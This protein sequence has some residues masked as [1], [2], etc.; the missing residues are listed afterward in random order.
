MSSGRRLVPALV[1][2]ALA[3]AI[4]SS[5]GLLLVPTIARAFGISVST[6]QWTLTLNLLVGA[7]ATPVLG[8]LSDGPHKKRILL[9][10]LVVILVGSVLAATA[11]TFGVLLA[12]RA[13]QGLSYAITR[14]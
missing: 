1:Y 7:I 2:A 14:R 8:R 10:T 3:A 11:P 13:L 5:L 6:A 12:G 9:V 4:I